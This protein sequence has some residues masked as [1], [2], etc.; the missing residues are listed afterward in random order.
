MTV[1][2]S[3]AQDQINDHVEQGKALLLANEALQ[4]EVQDLLAKIDELEF[5]LGMRDEYNDHLERANQILSG[6]L[7]YTMKDLEETRENLDTCRDD[8]V[9]QIKVTDYWRHL[10]M[11]YQLGQELGYT[12]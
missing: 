11:S 6:Q 2:L 5:A 4:S 7:E 1:N 3:M 8:F 10:A 12:R 9:K